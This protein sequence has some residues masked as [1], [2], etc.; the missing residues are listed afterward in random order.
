MVSFPLALL[1]SISMEMHDGNIQS[2][3]GGDSS[4]S[5]QGRRAQR[6]GDVDGVNVGVNVG[7]GVG[8]GDKTTGA[9]AKGETKHHSLNFYTVDDYHDLTDSHHSRVFVKLSAGAV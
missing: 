8:R 4:R 5:R 7:V 2:V 9:A 1:L 3:H 6:D